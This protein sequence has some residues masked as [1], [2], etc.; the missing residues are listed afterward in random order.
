MPRECDYQLMDTLF[1]EGKAA[2]IV[3][4]PWSW[5]DYRKAGID[6]GI[7]PLSDAA[8]RRLGRAHDREQGLLDQRERA[9]RPSCRW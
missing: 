7:A 3:N 4:G 1:K 9:P 8:G 6:L 5:S 2:M